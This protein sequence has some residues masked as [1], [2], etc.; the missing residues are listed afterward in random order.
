MGRVI[1]RSYP[2]SIDGVTTTYDIFGRPLSSTHSN[3]NQ[4]LYNYP[5][6]SNVVVTDENGNIT[7]AQYAYYG[8]M[9]LGSVE[10]QHVISP[11]S[12][13]TI[14]SRNGM[15]QIW[16]VFQGEENSQGQIAGFSRLYN[17]NVSGFL[18]SA[19]N[20]ET[21][22][23]EYTYDDVGN[24]L[25]KEVMG[26]GIIESRAYDGRN[27]LSTISYSDS[28]PDVSFS[29][30]DDDNLTV[31]SEERRVGSDARWKGACTQ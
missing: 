9:E 23:T 7:E 4:L 5:T 14:L 12:I 16:R 15:G 17:H 30:D 6:A 19:Q 28:T 18:V 11:E 31:S 3:G 13:R 2:N 8:S 27:R 22:I 29:Y 10:L 26:S 24:M 25:T 1:F 20:P 21:G